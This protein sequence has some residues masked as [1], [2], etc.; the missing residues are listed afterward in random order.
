MTQP[1]APLPGRPFLPQFNLPATMEI[2]C[3]SWSQ[4]VS[5]VQRVESLLPQIAEAGRAINHAL[6]AGR[7]LYSC[8]NGGSACD[9][10]HL[11][12][13]LTGRFRAERVSLPAVC[14]NADVSLLTC[15]GNDY[16]FDEVFARPVSGMVRPGDVVVGFST[17]GNSENVRRAMERAKAKG[18]VTIALLGRDGGVIR[19]LVDHA[20]VVPSADTARIQEIHTFILHV[21]LEMLEAEAWLQN[22]PV[23]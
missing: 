7:V 18:A 16:G 10:L 14:L 3:Q 20:L 23:V 1:L 13:E 8:G 2:A 5:V 15:I 9:A 19:D 6:E 11:A 22:R 17:S 21:W 4:L 12:E